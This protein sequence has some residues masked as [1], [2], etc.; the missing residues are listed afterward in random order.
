MLNESSAVRPTEMDLTSQHGAI[1][2]APNNNDGEPNN[3]RQQQQQ[4]RLRIQQSVRFAAF[5]DNIT[6]NGASPASSAAGV[7]PPLPPQAG[8]SPKERA[9]RPSTVIC[10]SPLRPSV[11]A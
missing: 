8:A 2:E 6:L 9:P 5:D 4:E 1:N 7:D 10:S 11:C 3:R